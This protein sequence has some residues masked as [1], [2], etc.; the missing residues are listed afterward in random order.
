MVR[1]SVVSIVNSMVHMCLCECLLWPDVNN[2]QICKLETFFDLNREQ[3]KQIYS[4]SK[5]YN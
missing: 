2:N 4:H 3:D 5:Q 1:Y